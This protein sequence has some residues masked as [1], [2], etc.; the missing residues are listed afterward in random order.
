MEFY[1]AINTIISMKSIDVLDNQKLFISI[2]FCDLCPKMQ[3]ERLFLK[4]V[5]QYGLAQE[6]KSKISARSKEQISTINYVKEMLQG[7]S[8][9]NNE[10]MIR[11]TNEFA[12]GIGWT[13]ILEDNSEIPTSVQDILINNTRTAYSNANKRIENFS[14]VWKN[15]S[16]A[17]KAICIVLILLSGMVWS[18]LFSD[19]DISGFLKEKLCILIVIM[20]SAFLQKVLC[21]KLYLTFWLSF[22]SGNRIRSIILLF[23]FIP[24][25]SFAIFKSKCDEVCIGR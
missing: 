11:F 20:L 9:L 8:E 1:E 5:F 16:I 6:V 21:K 13:G 25:K 4:C 22:F 23:A 7:K 2:F 3:K 12:K 18:S 14:Y 10:E 15:T 19:S 24:G 17:L